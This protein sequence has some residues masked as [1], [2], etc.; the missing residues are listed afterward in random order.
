MP[1]VCVTRSASD[2]YVCDVEPM[3]TMR[4]GLVAISTSTFAV[5]PRPVSRP[6]SGSR[7]TSGGRKGIS[8]ERNA[9]VHPASLPG[10][11]AST[12]TDAGGPAA[13]TFE[14][15]AGTLTARPVA[16]VTAICA[17]AHAHATKPSSATK[18][19]T[20]ARIRIARAS[21]DPQATARIRRMP[22]PM[23]RKWC[24]P[25]VRTSPRYASCPA[26]GQP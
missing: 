26:I 3:S 19:L 24:V 11:S 2:T 22:A 17:F 7:A 8:S 20:A 15:V 4:S 23:E 14:M 13:R 9:R 1:V 10:A 5:L 12:N 6:S 18:R 25:R 16:S 21:P